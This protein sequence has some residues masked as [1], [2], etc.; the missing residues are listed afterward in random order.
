MDRKKVA[1][2]GG[3]MRQVYMAQEFIERG[4]SV[5]C[6]GLAKQLPPCICNTAISLEEIISN[7]FIIVGPIP[8]TRDN[9]E[10]T[11][12]SGEVSLP[13]HEFIK[14]LTPD[15]LFFAGDLRDNIKSAL[16]SKQIAF[17]DFMDN[18]QV[19]ILNAIS[20]A[21]GT[22]SEAIRFSDIN[23]HSSDCLILGYGR[24]AKVLAKKLKG[25]DCKVTVAARKVEDRAYAN[26]YGFTAMALE[27]LE[28]YVADYPF[29]FNT[30]PA[31]VLTEPILRSL[32]TDVTI[33][34]IASAP[35][36]IDYS[37]CKQYGINAHLCLGLPGRF[38]PKTSA[39]ILVDTILHTK[40]TLQV[41]AATM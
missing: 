8:F 6:Y 39:Q 2:I 35:G 36:G 13:I 40:Q 18:N 23:L 3:D 37:F 32:S 17:F 20:T 21:E 10:L 11:K 4:Y 41:F 1:I 14:Y 22:I 38:A 34:D 33:I 29:I 19:A 12:I 31:L 7:H 26:A 28:N 15:H 5:S 27:Q 24:C 30:I 16:R 9:K 25:L